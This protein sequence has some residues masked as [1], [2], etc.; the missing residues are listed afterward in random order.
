LIQVIIT[1]LAQ[2]VCPHTCVN[3]AGNR[4]KQT[5]QR[6]AA[7]S[8]VAAETAQNRF[9]GTVKG[10]WLVGNDLLSIDIIPAISQ[11]IESDEIAERVISHV[12]EQV[13]GVLQANSGVGVDHHFQHPTVK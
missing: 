8:H 6:T 4:L 13:I 10:N 11:E 3:F 12:A 2:L 1:Q 5:R 7:E 9:H